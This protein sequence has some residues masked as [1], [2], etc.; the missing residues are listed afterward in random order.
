M[1][2]SLTETRF[3]GVKFK[4]FNVNCNENV[5]RIIKL[6]KQTS[7]TT[8]IVVRFRFETNYAV[9]DLSKQL[10]VSRGTPGIM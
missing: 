8:L 9:I 5:T 2:F 4:N 7:L 3:Y 6:T 1:T 10:G